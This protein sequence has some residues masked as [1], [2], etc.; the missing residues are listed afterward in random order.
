MWS[1]GCILV[2]LETGTPL[3]PAK[4]EQDL[5][6]YH[7]EF[8]GLPQDDVMSRASRADE[9]FAHGRPLR[10]TDRKGRHHPI[11]SRQLEDVLQN[12]DPVLLDFLR[13]CLTWNPAD[14]ITAAEALRHPWI[15]GGS[16]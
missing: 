8:L 9:F 14:R 2:E 7:M 3:F 4:N 11:H 13:R 10:H 1:L 5:P 12:P 6:L 16:R 15:V